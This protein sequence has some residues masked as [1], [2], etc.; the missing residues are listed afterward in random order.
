M[1]PAALTLDQLIEAATRGDE[2]AM[3]SLFEAYHRRLWRITYRIVGD[4]DAAHDV[5]QETFVR[6]FRNLRQFR[7][8]GPFEAW[9]TRIAI[10]AARDASKAERRRNRRQSSLVPLA[11]PE[12]LPQVSDPHLEERVR[13]AVLRLPE[14]ARVVLLMHDVEGFTHEQIAATLDIAAG[15]SRARLSRARS[16]LRLLLAG[17][18]KS[19]DG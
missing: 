5:V 16:A 6:A 13:A 17:L 11:E 9:L 14:S 15:S 18:E 4:Y 1:A 8:S 19:H 7:A 2:D 3:R 10:N 12:A